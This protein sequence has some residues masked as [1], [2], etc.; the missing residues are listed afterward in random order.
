MHVYARVHATTSAEG[1]AQVGWSRGWSSAKKEMRILRTV[2]SYNFKLQPF[3]DERLDSNPVCSTGVNSYPSASNIQ[4][5]APVFWRDDYFNL[6]SLTLICVFSSVFFFFWVYAVGLS[7][8]I[9]VLKHYIKNNDDWSLHRTKMETVDHGELCLISHCCPQYYKL[10]TFLCD[11]LDELTG[12]AR[13]NPSTVKAL[14]PA[15]FLKDTSCPLSKEGNWTSLFHRESSAF[16]H[17]RESMC[18]KWDRCAS[19]CFRLVWLGCICLREAMTD[20][21]SEK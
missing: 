3:P 19:V 16:L 13:E 7:N 11:H 6:L 18:L 17:E 9:L 8:S 15:C 2:G 1:R 5:M 10:P 14:F 20:N 4:R 21:R 12:C